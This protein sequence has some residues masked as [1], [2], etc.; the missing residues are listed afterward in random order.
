LLL[1]GG[2]GRGLREGAGW[3]WALCGAGMELAAGGG[4]GRGW[5]AAGNLTMLGS[6]LE[7]IQNKNRDLKV[8]LTKG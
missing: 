6:E 4:G 7:N 8:L 2:G 5:T 1:V 3:A